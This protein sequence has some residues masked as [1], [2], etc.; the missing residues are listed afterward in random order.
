MSH[1]AEEARGLGKRLLTRRYDDPPHTLASIDAA[2]AELAALKHL[3]VD[4]EDTQAL[5]DVLGE[6]AE[7]RLRLES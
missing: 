6:I 7:V 2:V 5:Q 1:V 4:A 3:A